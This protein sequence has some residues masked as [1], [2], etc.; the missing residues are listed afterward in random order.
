MNGE[1]MVDTQTDKNRSRGF[2]K[3]FLLERKPGLLSVAHAIQHM[4][5]LCGEIS[6]ERSGLRCSWTAE[7]GTRLAWNTRTE[8]LQKG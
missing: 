4:I 2:E 7:L 5:C 6:T 3:T 8:N 1:V